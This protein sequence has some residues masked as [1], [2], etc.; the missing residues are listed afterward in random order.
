MNEGEAMGAFPIFQEKV[1][2]SR[3]SSRQP[4]LAAAANHANMKRAGMQSC[5]HRLCTEQYG[6]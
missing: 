5:L 6:W 4:E 3:A 1:L 2:C